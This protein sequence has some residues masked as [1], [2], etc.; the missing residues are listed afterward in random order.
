MSD[1]LSAISDQ[2]SAKQAISYQ[3]SAVSLN[4]APKGSPNTKGNG[5]SDLRCVVFLGSP[6]GANPSTAGLW[7]SAPNPKGKGSSAVSC[8]FFGGPPYG[9]TPSPGGFW[10]GPPKGSRAGMRATGP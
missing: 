5:S 7:E 4:R 3:R 10:E 8:V 9:A 6:Y 2:R 1:Q